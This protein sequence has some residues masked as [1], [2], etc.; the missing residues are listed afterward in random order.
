[1][2]DFLYKVLVPQRPTYLV[3]RS[4]LNE[5]LSIIA[6]RRLITLSAPA[7]YGKTSLLV[8]FAA[9][10]PLPLCW[11]ALDS[12]DRDPWVFLDYLAASIEHRFPGATRQTAEMLAGHSRTSFAAVLGALTR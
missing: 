5:L 9:T 12:S 10:S 2:V 1:M 3:S 7:G 11:Y 4:R 6:D 8:D